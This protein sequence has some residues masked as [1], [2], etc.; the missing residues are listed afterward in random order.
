MTETTYTVET[1]I[2]NTYDNET[3]REFIFDLDDIA[4]IDYTPTHTLVTYTIESKNEANAK[5]YIEHKLAI[6]DITPDYTDAY[7]V[8][9][10]IIWNV[11]IDTTPSA[12]LKL[13]T[14]TAA[15]TRFTLPL[16][17]K[18]PTKLTMCIEAPTQTQ[19]HTRVCNLMDM[20]SRPDVTVSRA[21]KIS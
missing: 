6:H 21:V 11:T 1:A 8:T 9:N 17:E 20:L 2:P 15:K 14:N 7:I 18:D 19:A 12:H 5:H 4:T 10:P 16:F 13:T 3:I